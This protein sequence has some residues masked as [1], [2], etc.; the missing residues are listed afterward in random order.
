VGQI[1]DDI[2]AA[3]WRAATQLYQVAARLRGKSP[4]DALNEVAQ[5]AATDPKDAVVDGAAAANGLLAWLRSGVQIVDTVRRVMHRVG[6]GQSPAVAGLFIAESAAGAVGVARLP[7]QVR[8]ARADVLKAIKTGSREDE[9]KAIDSF[10]WAASTTA[11]G[12]MA[13]SAAIW[14]WTDRLAPYLRLKH[15]LADAGVAPQLLHRMTSRALASALQPG[16]PVSPFA[17]QA[18]AEL[19]KGTSSFWSVLAARLFAAVPVVYTALEALNTLKTH[20]DPKATP[21]EKHYA[22]LALAGSAL[23]TTSSLVSVATAGAATGLMALLSAPAVTG[24]AAVLGA[25]AWVYATYK[26]HQLK[27][28]RET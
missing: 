4:K 28:A 10:R 13:V 20:R 8:M 6:I 11:G 16:S 15:V 24:A 2:G 22:D 14:A 26:Q 18:A 21:Q 23:T 27:A 17:Q 5:E 12:V 3:T 25:A 9:L 7:E 1:G 19:A